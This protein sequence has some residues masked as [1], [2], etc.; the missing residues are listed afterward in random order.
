MIETL[1]LRTT[2]R[3]DSLG[4]ERKAAKLGSDS[5]SL[6]RTT[7]KGCMKWPIPSLHLWR[8][9]FWHRFQVMRTCWT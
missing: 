9:Q 2:T 4:G 6:L 5:V 1:A 8:E 7:A 3:L